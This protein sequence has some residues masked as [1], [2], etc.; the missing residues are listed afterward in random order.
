MKILVVVWGL[1]TS[2]E[3]SRLITPAEIEGEQ[4]PG[5]LALQ[6]ADGETWEW[7]NPL[8]VQQCSGDA[9]CSHTIDGSPTPG[10]WFA[11]F[12]DGNLHYVSKVKLWN[13]GALGDRLNNAC[14]RF[15]TD[16]TKPSDA[17]P[18]QSE[19]PC[20]AYLPAAV[21]FGTDVVIDRWITGMMFITTKGSGDFH[22]SLCGIE[23]Y[24]MPAT[25][26]TY[27]D[28]VTHCSI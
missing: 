2:A 10:Y 4:G 9:C 12:K 11:K 26:T 21:E 15:T 22:F 25:T 13:R 19:N 3:S 24:E 18:S 8:Y 27:S 28:K 20:D 23:I 14:V 7:G 6:G 1:I 17:D 5:T 16:G